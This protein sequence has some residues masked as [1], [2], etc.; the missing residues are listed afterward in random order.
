MIVRDREII[1]SVN[2]LNNYVGSANYYHS[3]PN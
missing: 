1:K 3:L 2:L